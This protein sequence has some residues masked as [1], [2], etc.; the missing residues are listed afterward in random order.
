MQTRTISGLTKQERAP[1]S[2][3]SYPNLV[4]DSLLPVGL[5]AFLWWTSAN[6]VSLLQAACALFLALV[7]WS[8]YRRWVKSGEYDLPFPAMISFMFWTYYSLPLFW[9]DRYVSDV[10]SSAGKIV[11]DQTV[12]LTMLMAV[13]GVVSLLLG[14]K[15]RIS[16]RLILRRVPD[17]KLNESALLYLRLVLILGSLINL[18]EPSAYVFGEGG[19]QV[20][21]NL[22]TACPTVAFVILLRR[23]YRKECALFDKLLVFGYLIIRVLGGIS[24]GWLGSLSTTVVI[25]VA[26]YIAERRKIPLLAVCSLILLVMFLQVG[27]GEFRKQYWYGEQRASQVERAGFWFNTSVDKWEGLFNDPNNEKLKELTSQSVGR[28]SLLAQTA[29]V[30]ELTPSAVPYQYGQLYSYILVTLIPRFVWPDKPSVNEANRFYQVSYNL[31]TEDNLEGVSISVGF[32]AESYI[33]F[34]WFG[35]AVIM[36]LIGAFLKLFQQTFMTKASGWLLSSMGIVLLPPLLG[37]EGQLAVYLGG[38]LQ[39]TL[40]IIVVFLPITRFNRRSST[41]SF[42]PEMSR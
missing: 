30:V 36:F 31:T 28:L 21:V 40:L 23:Y 38:L 41:Q 32:L 7:A 25:C 35:V 6:D 19:R 2:A 11:T 4:Q 10:G 18:F 22:L 3:T 5:T 27:K 14:M 42:V 17:I 13:L 33:N 12:T 16:P 29:N 20:V 1:L 34:G 9:G 15:V 8:S 37:V 39:Q 24:S 26:V